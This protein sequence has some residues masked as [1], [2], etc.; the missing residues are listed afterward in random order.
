[1]HFRA[2]WGHNTNFCSFSAKNRLKLKL[3]LL[4]L[5]LLLF[6]WQKILT[7]VKVTSS[8][9]DGKKKGKLT[10]TTTTTTTTAL[11]LC[12]TIRL[13]TIQQFENLFLALFT[14][15]S[16]LKE[17]LKTFSKRKFE[18]AGKNRV[19]HIYNNNNSYTVSECFF[20]TFCLGMLAS[21][22]KIIFS[23]KNNRN[24]IIPFF[25]DRN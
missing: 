4:L 17:T 19:C 10:T 15:C 3:K 11:F 14:Y 16:N 25:C 2:P 21:V 20:C 9:R 13:S 8:T 6:L 12:I 18:M 7:S 23:E 22:I 1:M 24:E 5:L